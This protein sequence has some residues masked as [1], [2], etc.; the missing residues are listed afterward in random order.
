MQC[1]DFGSLKRK[2]GTSVIH[3][4]PYF[5]H[6]IHSVD[7]SFFGSLELLL[8]FPICWWL[9]NNLLR[10]VAVC[11]VG[12]LM[13]QAYVI[14]AAMGNAVNAITKWQVCLYNVSI[15]CDHKFIRQYD[16]EDTGRATSSLLTVDILPRTGTST[17]LAVDSHIVENLNVDSTGC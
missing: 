15:F 8:L 6:K 13:G 2:R 10:A 17:V 5:S 1:L 4:L 9:E 14:G 11:Q 16:S 7:I 12:Q 3:L